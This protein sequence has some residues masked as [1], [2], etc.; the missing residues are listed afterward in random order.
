M[1]KEIRKLIYSVDASVWDGN[2]QL[3]GILGLSSNCISFNFNDFA[4]SH[5]ML[6]IPLNEIKEV[7][8]F[9]IYELARG[10][11]RIVNINGHFD[12]FVLENAAIFKKRLLTEISKFK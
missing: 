4:K 7:E 10:G 11:L 9:L 5:L 6:Q 1:K 2:F 3:P 12:L 8:E